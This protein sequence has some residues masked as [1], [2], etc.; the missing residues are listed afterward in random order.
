MCHTCPDLLKMLL[1][2]VDGFENCIKNCVV[3]RIKKEVFVQCLVN[4]VFALRLF[5]DNISGPV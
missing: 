3:S 2:F 5:P 4:A 1:S